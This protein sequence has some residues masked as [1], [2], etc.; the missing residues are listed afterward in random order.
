[1]GIDTSVGVSGSDGRTGCGGWIDAP[2]RDST[3]LR[4][5]SDR[6]T[7]CV[8]EIAAAAAAAARDSSDLGTSS[9]G[10]Y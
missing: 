9:D 5:E 6:G 10:I 3:Y 8:E 4:T 7:G 1:M 2:G